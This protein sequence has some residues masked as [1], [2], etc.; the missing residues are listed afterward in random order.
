MNFG[1]WFQT[2]GP[3]W[4]SRRLRGRLPVPWLLITGHLTV[5]ASLALATALLPEETP[6][7][8]ALASS[9]GL[10]HGSAVYRRSCAMCHDES[11]HGKPQLGTPLAGAP[12]LKV[13]RTDHFAAIL[14][15]GVTGPILGSHAYHPIMPG[16]GNWLDDREIADVASYV[17]HTWGGRNAS[18]APQIVAD[19]RAANRGRMNPWTLKELSQRPH[20]TPLIPVP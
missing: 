2:H 14:L 6:L 1:L 12:W 18:V 10:A 15:Y 16:L 19:I 5:M 13:C 4:T 9:D 8:A 20:A 7:A 11:G 3:T 17:L